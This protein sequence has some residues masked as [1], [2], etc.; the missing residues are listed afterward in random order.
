MKESDLQNY[1]RQLS[2]RMGW[3]W[4]KGAGRNGVADDW[5]MKQG[6][7]FVVE[8]KTTGKKS[9]QRFGQKIEQENCGKCGVPYYL[10]DTLE[11]F[12]D[13]LLIEEAKIAN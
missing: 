10:I 1:S 9:G 3:M 6:R 5:F 11:E 4:A 7:G 13:V 12:K 8:F 2:E